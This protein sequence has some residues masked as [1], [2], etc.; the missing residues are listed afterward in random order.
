MAKRMFKIERNRKVEHVVA[1]APRRMDAMGSQTT[2]LFR[3]PSHASSYRSRHIHHMRKVADRLHLHLHL[4]PPQPTASYSQPHSLTPYQP[5]TRKTCADAE[6]KVPSAMTAFDTVRRWVFGSR[7]W[8]DDD[9]GIVAIE[10]LFCG[11][12]M[13]GR[14]G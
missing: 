9:D 7:G 2:F 10:A 8:D 4:R 6:R 3:S 12:G 5:G 14:W 11:G 13:D 1:S